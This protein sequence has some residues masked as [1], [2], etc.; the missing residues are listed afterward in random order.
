[1]IILILIHAIAKA[2]CDLIKFKAYPKGDWWL[3]K[4]KYSY[5]KRTWL[6]KVPFS[7][8]SDGWHLFETIK[9]LSLCIAIVLFYGWAWWVVIFLYVVHGII[10]EI[11]YNH[12]YS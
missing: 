6:L 11:I 8:L 7:F 1:M 3:A 5:D 4:G 2:V 12:K 9:V 10:F